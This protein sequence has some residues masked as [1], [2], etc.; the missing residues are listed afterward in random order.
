MLV[1][2]TE[3]NVFEFELGPNESVLKQLGIEQ[4]KKSSGG[5]GM[6]AMGMMMGGGM[7]GLA[8]AYGEL[9][10]SYKIVKSKIEFYE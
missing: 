10:R 8:D 3:E 4:G 7:G 2:S 1:D 9:E 6:G 5:M